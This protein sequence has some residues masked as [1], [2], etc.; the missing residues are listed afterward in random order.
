MLKKYLKIALLSMSCIFIITG[1]SNKEDVEKN[2]SSEIIEENSNS[3]NYIDIEDVPILG[4]NDTYSDMNFKDGKE[5]VQ[6]VD[7][8]FLNSYVDIENKSSLII[9]KSTSEENLYY[10]DLLDK[11]NAIY[12]KVEYTLKYVI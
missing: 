2:N 8:S 3:E 4:V 11:N 7:D 6:N 12:E 5:F 10:F 1:C 9:S